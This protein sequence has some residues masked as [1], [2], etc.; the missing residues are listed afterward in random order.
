MEDLDDNVPITPANKAFKL[1]PFWPTNPWACFTTAEG[2]FNLKGISDEL[3]RFFNCL[4]AF[5]EATVVLI[6]N[7]V[8]AVMLLNGAPLPPVGLARQTAASS[9][10]EAFRAPR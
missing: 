3:S 8:E 4:H 5:P 7:L 1:P 2:T 10:Q 9:L 6:A